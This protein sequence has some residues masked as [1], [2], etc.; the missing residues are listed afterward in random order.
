MENPALAATHESPLG[1]RIASMVK[2]NE[3][4]WYRL[5]ERF[6]MPT[7]YLFVLTSVLYQAI[8]WTGQQVVLPAAKAHINMVTTVGEASL[9]QAESFRSQAH[10]MHI[11]AEATKEQK[12]ASAR[13]NELLTRLVGNGDRKEARDLSK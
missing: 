9:S 5:L 3:P 2:G 13:T 7:A 4:F 12:E 6:G 1:Q 11:I 8:T 10:A